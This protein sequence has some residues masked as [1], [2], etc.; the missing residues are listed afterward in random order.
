[1]YP[2]DSCSHPAYMYVVHV[3]VL[4]GALVNADIFKELCLG[5][6]GRNVIWSCDLISIKL[7]GR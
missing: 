3:H 4:R 7:I 6:S 5:L 1:M 2:I